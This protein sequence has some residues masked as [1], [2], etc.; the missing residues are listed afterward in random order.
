VRAGG[1]MVCVGNPTMTDDEV[2]SSMAGFALDALIDTAVEA[3]RVLI[4]RDTVANGA[5]SAPA[6]G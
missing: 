1:L 4:E 3:L 5:S 2:K 6:A